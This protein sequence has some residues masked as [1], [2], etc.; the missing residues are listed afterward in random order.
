MVSASQWL[1]KTIIIFCITEI[2]NWTWTWTCIRSCW[3]V[4]KC[5]SAN[6]IRNTWVDLDGQIHKDHGCNKAVKIICAS[7]LGYRQISD[8]RRAL[9]DNKIVYH[10]DVFVDWRRCSNYIFILEL[11][12]GFNRSLKDNCETRRETFKFGASILEVWRY[13]VFW[14]VGMLLQWSAVWRKLI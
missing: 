12:R 5:T 4:V 10:L 2:A 9:V 13:I 1:M 8:I 14:N 7:N 3:Y 11:S 6:L